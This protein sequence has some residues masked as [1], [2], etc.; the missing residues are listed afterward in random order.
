M[1]K[2]LKKSGFILLMAAFLIMACACQGTSVSDSP[3][4]GGEN[5]QDSTENGKQPIDYAALANEL[6][7]LIKDDTMSEMKEEMIEATYGFSPDLLDGEKIYLSSGSTANEVAVFSCKNEEDTKKVMDALGERV[8]SREESYKEYNAKEAEKLKNAV[9]GSKG[10]CVI[11][12]VVEDA[13]AA[14]EILNKY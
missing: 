6:N 5:T 7:S 10:N 8:K 13:A 3:N 12:V 4:N 2:A 9:I 11:L 14:K 1:F